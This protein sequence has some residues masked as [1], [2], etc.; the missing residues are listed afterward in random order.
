MK[1]LSISTDRSI[2]KDSSA[3]L[4]RQKD[5]AKQ[6]NELY[7]VVFSLKKANLEEFHFGNLHV[8][9]T[10]SK[11]R[12]SYISDAI[13]LSRKII[14]DSGLN[15]A[16]SVITTQDPFETG[17]VGYVLKKEFDLSLQMQVHT[18]FSSRYFVKNIFSLNVL[19]VFMAYFLIPKADGVRTVSFSVN[20][21]L[22]KRK[23]NSD[24][25]PIHV[26]IE[27]VFK[28]PIRENAK[29]TFSHFDQ[30]IFV[31]SRLEKEKRVD[32]AINVFNLVLRQFP[33]A[34]LII[35][36]S[37]REKHNLM[38]LANKLKIKNNIK[39][40]NKIKHQIS[41]FKTTDVFLNTS[42]YEGYGMTLIEAQAAGSFIVTTRV[43]VANTDSFAFDRSTKICEVGDVD[44][45]ASAVCDFLGLDSETKKTLY[46]QRNKMITELGRLQWDEYVKKYVELLEQLLTKK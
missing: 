46:E 24:I 39:F 30:L 17:W 26:D 35:A 42:E 19:R 33:N 14:N 11:S 29:D 27:E 10:N 20:Q 1:V 6:M 15:K 28:R 8:Y 2:F 37:G 9:P 12:W 40:V 21:A 5:Y 13:K 34:G 16:D 44:N 31:I 36:G 3:V 18:D 22:K 43:G 23:I 4:K 7:V 41:Y 45:L 32:V 25:L 38:K